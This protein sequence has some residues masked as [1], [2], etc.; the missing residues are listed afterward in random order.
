MCIIDDYDTIN[1]SNK[2][3]AK[4]MKLMNSVATNVLVE[5]KKYMDQFTKQQQQDVIKDYYNKG[6]DVSIILDNQYTHGQMEL[7]MR[8]MIYRENVSQYINPKYT[9]SQMKFI[10]DCLDEDID[11]SSFNDPKFSKDQMEEIRR[12]LESGIDVSKYAFP[13]LASPVM[14]QKRER[15]EYEQMLN[16]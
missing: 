5:D 1:L 10:D 6:H 14:R 2:R 11:I 7:L 12:G 13:Y 9:Y 8:S 15:L 4:R 3:G 16:A